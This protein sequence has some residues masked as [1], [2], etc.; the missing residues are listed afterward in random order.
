MWPLDIFSKKKKYIAPR[1]FTYYSPRYK[2]SIT[3]PMGY[4]S[5]GATYAPDLSNTAFFIHDWLCE[6]NGFDDGT[7]ATRLQASWVY[8]DIL[9][10]KGFWQHR[11][12]RIMTYW[13]GGKKLKKK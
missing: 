8:A 3:V 1:E 13:F 11:H 4:R 9:K 2:K 6:E 5:D 10:E 12:R 7:P